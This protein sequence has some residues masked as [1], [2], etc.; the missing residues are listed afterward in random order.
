MVKYKLYLYTIGMDLST[1][2]PLVRQLR[3][4][5]DGV[6]SGDYSLDVVD[7]AKDPESAAN[8]GVLFTPTLLRVHPEPKKRVIGNFQDKE[9]MMQAILFLCSM[10]AA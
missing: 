2:A 10:E 5:L 4:V 9:R 3:E 1:D 6:L 8:E 7:V